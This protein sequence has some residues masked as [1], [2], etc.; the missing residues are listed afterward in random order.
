MVD[1]LEGRVSGAWKTPTGLYS[2]V[3]GAWET[4][5][6]G[7]ARVSGAWEQ[8]YP[9]TWPSLVSVSSDIGTGDYP[10]NDCASVGKCHRCISWEAADASDT[11]EHIHVQVSVE[12]GT[13][14]TAVDDRDIE[15]PCTERTPD[16]D[17]DCDECTRTSGTGSD[18]KGCYCAGCTPTG[19]STQHKVRLETDGGD[20]LAGPSCELTGSSHSTCGSAA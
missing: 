13:Y 20:V 3:S 5:T 14:G 12:G 17:G 8:F 16:G 18:L 7:Y 9:T 4:A 19:T 10:D 1:H 2:R 6:A 11:T 15:F